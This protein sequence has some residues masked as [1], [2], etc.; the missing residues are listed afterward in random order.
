MAETIVVGDIHGGLKALKQVIEKIGDLTGYKFIFLGD[1]VDG[2]SESA[3]VIAYLIEFSKKNKSVFL[4]GNHDPLASDWLKG[5]PADHIWLKHGGQAT[6]DSYLLVNDTARAI[7]IEFFDS[8]KDFYEDDAERLFIHA[9]FTSV[10][11]PHHE[12]HQSTLIWDRSLWELALAVDPLMSKDSKRY[13]ARLLLYKEIFIGHTP[14]THI[15]ETTPVKSCNVWNIDTGAAAKGRLTAMNID[16][17][18]FWQSDKLK[19]LYPLEVER[20]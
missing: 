17:K 16:T 14:I 8:L 15:G 19:E 10:K 6:C 20:N 12:G 3:A 7:H 9:G 11:G 5:K 4:R 1:Y 18:V 2:W 13:P